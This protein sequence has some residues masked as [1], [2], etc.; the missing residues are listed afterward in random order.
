MC[1]SM[2]VCVA[3]QR[4]S[5]GCFSKRACLWSL[6]SR[7]NL[8]RAPRLDRGRVGKGGGGGVRRCYHSS[9]LQQRPLV[10]H[11]MHRTSLSF[12]PNRVLYL[13]KRHW[14]DLMYIAWY[15]STISS[16]GSSIFGT[17]MGSPTTTKH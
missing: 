16:V 15:I 13:S 6:Q 7:D 3:I 14:R 10:F 17:V 4:G 5:K 2:C 1:R 9:E 12:R 11:W 8:K